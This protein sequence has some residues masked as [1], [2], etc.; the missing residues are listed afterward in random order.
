M[1]LRWYLLLLLWSKGVKVSQ[2]KGEQEGLKE[3]LSQTEGKIYAKPWDPKDCGPSS[4]ASHWATNCH[5]ST[6][7]ALLEKSSDRTLALCFW[8]TNLLFLL[9]CLKHFI[10]SFTLQNN[11]QTS[12]QNHSNPGP[13]PNLSFQC[14]FLPLSSITHPSLHS[15]P[16]TQNSP[17]NFL[18]TACALMALC[19]TPF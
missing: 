19:L 18:N 14:H 5:Q 15:L 3:E 11:I 9:T 10:T 2:V 13:K 12:Q 17:P 1:L 8:N 6:D 7:T 16:A 4:V